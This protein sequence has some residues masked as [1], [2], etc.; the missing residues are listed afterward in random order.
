MDWKTERDALINE[1][2]ALIA[3]AEAAKKQ[4]PIQ[5]PI[6]PIEP[7]ETT[8]NEP[9]GP[10]ALPPLNLGGSER[11]QIG[12]RVENFR[13]HQERMRR[14]R[15]DYFSRTMQ[16]ARETAKGRPPNDLS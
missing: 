14:E 11:E 6:V 16:R 13:A 4:S 15:E 10:I 5:K 8:I 1:A 3:S 9:F 7:S 2:M 12:K